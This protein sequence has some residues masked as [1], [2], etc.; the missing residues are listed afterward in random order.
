MAQHSE[1]LQI[2]DTP[3]IVWTA[4]N[5][6]TF[7][8]IFCMYLVS[9]QTKVNSPDI[10]KLLDGKITHEIQKIWT[11]FQLPKVVKLCTSSVK[12]LQALPFITVLFKPGEKIQA[13]AFMRLLGSCNHHDSSAIVALKILRPVEPAPENR[14]SCTICQVILKMFKSHFVDRKKSFGNMD[15]LEASFVA[16]VCMTLYH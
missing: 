3:F 4:S 15:S 11:H 8:E 2:L 16:S 7:E 14:V 6:L 9:K 10:R 5:F 1:L 13:R 12:M